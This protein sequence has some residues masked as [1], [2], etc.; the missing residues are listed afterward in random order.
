MSAQI[1]RTRSLGKITAQNY[2]LREN[3]LSRGEYGHMT[4]FIFPCLEKRRWLLSVLSCGQGSA[5]HDLTG[6]LTGGGLVLPEPVCLRDAEGPQLNPSSGYPVSH[7]SIHLSSQPASQKASINASF[8][9]GSSTDPWDSAKTKPDRN[10]C[11]SE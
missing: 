11:P 1:Y 2:S 4:F 7:P 10:L 5:G 8:V 6:P 9:P 3:C